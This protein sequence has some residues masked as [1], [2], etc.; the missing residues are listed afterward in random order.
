MVAYAREFG[1]DEE[2]YA[3]TGLLHDL[4]Y[5]RHPDLGSGHPRVAL[6]LFEDSGYPQELIDAV[7]GHA[8]L[9]G[10]SARD[11]H[12]QDAVR[13]RRAVGLHLRV[14]L[15][16]PGRHPRD[17]AEVREE[18]AEAAELRGR[19]EPRGGARGRRGARRG[20]RRARG[21]RD[22][23]DVRARTF[24]SVPANPWRTLMSLSTAISG[25]RSPVRTPWPSS[26]SV[27][28]AGNMRSTTIGVDQ[29]SPLSVERITS[30]PGPSTSCGRTAAS[31]AASRWRCPSP[32]TEGA[33]GARRSVSARSAA[34]TR[35]CHR[36]RPREPSA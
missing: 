16:A 22:R 25:I 5:E 9:P 31:P 24:P 19:S 2:L 8:T 29:V 4:D 35:R 3:V 20:L 30:A 17:D 28:P 10:R 18:E 12:G 27:T 33:L 6:K 32:R 34:Q 7:A 14:R 15:R 21:I 36:R 1:E 23:G 26:G 11:A 13:R